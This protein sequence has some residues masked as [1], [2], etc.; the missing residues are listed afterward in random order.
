MIARS[1]KPYL[2]Y[3]NEYCDFDL[4]NTRS[5]LPD[6]DSQF[7]PITLEYLRRVINFQR[8]QKRAETS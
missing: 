4:T 5:I 2:P 8:S 3:L 7:S 1:F 6:Y